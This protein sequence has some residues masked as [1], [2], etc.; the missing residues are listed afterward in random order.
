ML[1]HNL[2]MVTEVAV[3]GIPQNLV[4]ALLRWHDDNKSV[5]ANTGA[6]ALNRPWVSTTIRDVDATSTVC[7]SIPGSPWNPVFVK[8]FP[9]VVSILNRLPLQH[10]ER[11]YLLETQAVCPAHTD[12]SRL[13][14]DDNT[15]EPCNYR[16]TLRESTSSS[17]FYVQPKEIANWGGP[18]KS[19]TSPIINYWACSIGK[20]WT[21]NNFICQHGS[22][23]SPGDHKVI[24]SVQGTPNP[25]THPTTLIASEGLPCIW[26]PIAYEIHTT[27]TSICRLEL[28]QQ[29][30]TRLLVAH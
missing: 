24:I 12:M 20:W 9:Q 25:V 2:K 4:T 15:L 10:I 22:D 3:P 17:G 7:G 28:I 11:I 6:V 21:L 27:P 16:M 30:T 1:R 13:L 29:A 5:L 19:V 26:H 18:T 8:Q 23:Y 14:Y